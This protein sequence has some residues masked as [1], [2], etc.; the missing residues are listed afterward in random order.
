[1]R[2]NRLKHLF[3]T[4]KEVEIK[5]TIKKIV[6]DQEC[7]ETIRELRWAEGIHCVTCGSEKVNSHGGTLKKRYLCK[8]CGKSFDDLTGTIFSG[9]KEPLKTWVLCLYFMGLNLSN[10][11][12]GEELDVSENTALSMTEQLRQ[13]IVKKK[14]DVQLEGE[15]EFDEVYII[16]GHKGNSEKVREKGRPPRRRRL[17][18]KRGRGT[19]ETEKAPILGMIQR[20]GEVVMRMLSN[21]QKKTI[22]PIIKKFVS[23]GSTVYTDEYNIYNSLEKWGY[24]HLTV[25]HSKGEY[26]RDED[27]D[28]FHEIH[29][30]T[31]EG[32]WSLLRS[33]IRPH[34]GISQEKLPL[35]VGFFEFIHNARKRGK[36]LLHKLLNTIVQEDK[37]KIEDIYP[38]T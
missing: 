38:A 4:K 35:Y 19:L 15:V 14:P 28:G 27:G 6:S 18:G 22:K 20:S 13:G 5:I 10:R 17:K 36:T 24:T 11:Q 25:N 30:N 3:L 31:M 29:V 26:A 37:R 33:W 8:S 1:M 32:T 9:S 23:K 21:V 34:R 12:I 16:A 2:F 7:Y